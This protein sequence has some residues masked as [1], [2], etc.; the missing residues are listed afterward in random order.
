MSIILSKTLLNRAVDGVDA[1][2]VYEINLTDLRGG[3]QGINDIGSPVSGAFLPSWVGNYAGTGIEHSIHQKTIGEYATVFAFKPDIPKKSLRSFNITFEFNDISG[4]NP[5][6]SG[7][8]GLSSSDELSSYN[9][10][11]YFTTDFSTSPVYDF[12]GN[13][14]QQL[15]DD[16]NFRTSLNLT[17]LVSGAIFSAA[18]TSSDALFLT[19]QQSDSSA[20]RLRAM[21]VESA[22]ISYYAVPPSKPLLPIASGGDG[23]AFLTWQQ[24]ADNG[25]HDVTKYNIEYYN[26]T[27]STG[28]AKVA[29]AATGTSAYIYDLINDN[30]YYFRVSATNG[31]GTSPFSDDSNSV[32]LEEPIFVTPLDFNHANYT[33]I[34][35]RRDTSSNWTGINPILAIGEAAYETDTRLLKIGDN[36]TRW[37]DLGY[38]KVENSSIDFPPPS[39]V[40]L[41]IGDSPVN[42]DSPKVNINL[43][44]SEK[45]NVIGTGGVTVDYDNSFNSLTFS[46]DKVFS[47]F[48]SGTLH[49]PSTQGKAGDVY[50]DEKYV[51]ICVS[52][53]SWKR[54]LLPTTQWF[55]AD[56]LGISDID[57]TYSSVTSI[58]FSGSNLIVTADGDP[59]PAKAG[60]ALV[61]DGVSPRGAFHNNYTIGE[62]DYNFQIQYRGGSNTS[63]PEAANTGYLGVFNNGVVLSPPGASG[64]AIGLYSAPSGFVYN[65]SHFSSY[66]NM[67]DCGGHVNFSR[68]YAYYNGKFLKRC[69][70]D[71]KVYNSNPYYSGT[72]YNGDYFRHPDG[73]SKILGFAFDGYPIYGPFGYEYSEHA[74][75]GCA[76]MT[77][78]Y[79]TKATDD[80]RP[81]DYKYTNAISVN[82]INYNLTAGAYLQDFEYAEGSGLLDQYNGRYAVTPEYPEGTY[83]YYLTFTSSGLLVPSYPY[84]IGPFT[85]QK[86]VN[87][88]ITPSL[89]PLTVDGYFPVFLDTASASNYGLLNGGDGTYHTH[90]I[91]GQLYYM[92]NG[93]TFVHPTAPTDLALSNASI[94]EKAPLGAIVGT[95]TS[96]DTNENDT[97]TYSLATGINA[98]D[99]DNF[100]I[101]NNELRVNSILSYGIKPTHDIRIRTTDQTNRFFEKDFTIAVVQGSTLTSLSIVSGTS[102][103]LGGSG[104]VFGSD[105]SGTATDLQY[106]WSL[107]GSPYAGGLTSSTGTFWSVGTTNV[108]ERN[109]ET[110]NVSLSV[111][112]VSAYTTL[113][114]TTS[115]L[116]DHS[117]SPVC[118]NGYYPL[119]ASEYDANRDP[120]GNGT[121]HQHTV[122]AVVYWMPNGLSEHYHGDYDCDSFTP[123]KTDIC[124]D[125]SIDVTIANTGDGNRYVFDSNS[126]NTHRFKATTGTYVFNNVPSNHP[127]AFHNNGKPIAYSGTTSVGTKTALDGNT[128]NFYYGS[129]TGVFSGDFSTTSYECYYHGY[130]GGQDN[131]I[132]DN[133]CT[134]P[135]PTLTATQIGGLS[136]VNGG[137]SLTLTASKTGTATD[138]TYAWTVTAANGVTLS[139]S[140]GTSVNLNTTD[141]DQDADQNVTV[142]LTATSVSAGTSVTDSHA[143]TV[144]QSSDSSAPT[145]TS[146]TI[147][148]NTTVNGGSNVALSA[149]IVGTAIDV[150]YAWSINSVNGTA[151]SSSSGSTTTLTTTDLNTDTDQTVIVTV[152]ASSV[153]A[154]STVSD[155]QTITIYQSADGGGGGGGY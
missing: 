9:D 30:K 120:N 113:T 64:E 133:S 152:Q 135:T 144:V 60:G 56:Q 147:S 130:M 51:Y 118:V 142:T 8:V 76:L 112:S 100:N 57:G 13:I 145:L 125:G 66:F 18:Y 148:S 83:A 20:A 80:H 45:I 72:N 35:I 3:D 153:S 78:S 65:R 86:K 22:T 42:A 116:L 122:N 48:T 151:L 138:V 23:S 105:V 47:P 4:Y 11:N 99:N 154:S 103:L 44:N 111:T 71:T 5:D 21:S 94:S 132:Y 85:K 2:K 88:N 12:G 31:A 34:R 121:S 15:P 39:A 14:S 6:I 117:E 43:S 140:T 91:L 141:L 155:T 46:L 124:L 129:V 1:F 149:S 29:T 62:Q 54:I 106:Q 108:H 32:L 131:L 16:P 52:L 41:V 84:A 127:I 82:D 96:T 89:V 134:S 61:N 69:W 146:V 26:Q 27:V 55:T 128:Y 150:T 74:D 40:N 107:I 70:E 81:T 95:L 87:Q 68:Q 79:I 90:T 38:V 33:R 50:Y 114:D 101:V 49:S 123:S 126:S 110:V 77:T 93:V 73:H 136:S 137:S 19:F 63:S 37:N 28:W 17:S 53:N 25:G 75:S 24:P 67:D 98:T 97:F 139:S 143:V 115:F 36:S 109:D 10:F 104:N 92:P 58:Y 119:Y 7:V 102:I 59:Y